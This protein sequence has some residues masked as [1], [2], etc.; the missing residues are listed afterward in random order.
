MEAAVRRVNWIAVRRQKLRCPIVDDA[1]RNVW[2]GTWE[3]ADFFS[4]PQTF[5]TD[6]VR[7]CIVVIEIQ[8]A[9]CEEHLVSH[10]RIDDVRQVSNYRTACV[11]AGQLAGD[12]I[13]R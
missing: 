10:R 7:V 2:I 3:E 12:L 9:T 4:Q 8:L 13:G 6:F 11:V 5:V 1:N